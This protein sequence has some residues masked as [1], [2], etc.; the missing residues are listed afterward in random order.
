MLFDSYWH[1]L[2]YGHWYD[3]LHRIWYLLFDWNC[4]GFHDRHGDRLDDRNVDGIGLSNTYRHRMGHGYR[5]ALCHWDSYNLRKRDNLFCIFFSFLCSLLSI[6][7][8]Q[9][10]NQAFLICHPR[11]HTILILKKLINLCN[12]FAINDINQMEFILVT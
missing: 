10:K 8:V 12:I 3:F 5:Y 1:R 7:I 4:D 11:H 9:E 2:Y 6:E